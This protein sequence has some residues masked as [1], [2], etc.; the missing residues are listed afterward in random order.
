MSSGRVLERHVFCDPHTEVNEEKRMRKRL[1][2]HKKASVGRVFAGVLLGGL[3]GA[4]VR[5]LAART[6]R[7]RARE[8]IKTSEGNVESQAR[9]LLEMARNQKNSF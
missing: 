3:V 6:S 5:W 4:T 9:E 8:K 1:R 7:M 2:H